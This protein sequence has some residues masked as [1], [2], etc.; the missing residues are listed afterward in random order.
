MICT[1]CQTAIVEGFQFC[2]ACGSQVAVN[3]LRIADAGGLAGRGARLEAV[4]LDTVIF[5]VVVIA[6]VILLFV[7]PWLSLVLGAGFL[8]TE[9][10]MLAKDGQ[11]L[12]KKALGIRI[13]KKDTGQN[14]GFVTNVL[15]RLVLNG[16]LGFIPLYGLVDALF[17]FREDR[18]CI[19]DFIAGTQV[20][21][22]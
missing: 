10:V 16:L 4:I 9:T 19:H 1:T 15:L 2:M 3:V 22:A 18:R 21:E 20:V 11:T 8:I 14:G 7:S 17:I 5:V 12:G 13:V 6:A